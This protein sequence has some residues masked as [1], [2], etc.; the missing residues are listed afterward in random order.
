MKEWLVPTETYGMKTDKSPNLDIIKIKY[1]WN[2]RRV[3]KMDRRR[4][5]EVKCRVCV[6]KDV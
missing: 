2:M 3:V 1:L 6:R 5:E 4:N